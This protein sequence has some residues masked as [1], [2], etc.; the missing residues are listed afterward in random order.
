MQTWTYP[1]KSGGSPYT[2]TLADDGKMGCT[3]RGWL[4][5]KEGKP[6]RC[7]HIDQA[8]KSDAL[9]LEAR[10]DYMYAVAKGAVQSALPDPEPV[11]LPVADL[12]A[13]MLASK[14]PNPVKRND[15][16]S[17]ALFE[18]TYATGAFVLE[19]K[20]DGE[21]GFIVKSG[22]AVLAFSRPRAGETAKARE[23]SPAIAAA[24][25][26]VGDS[27]IDG[28]FVV[29]GG[30]SWDVKRIGA[31]VMFIAFDILYVNGESCMAKTYAERRLLLLTELAK[32]P[33]DQKVVSTVL[34]QPVAWATVEAIWA[35]GGEGAILK[36][37]SSTYR[38]TRS[39]DW[40]KVKEENSK[41]VTIIGF[42][43]AKS[44][45][46]SKVVVR[47]PNGKETSVKSLD[48]ATRR[49]M[50]ANP[51]KYLGARLVINYH[52]ETP[53]GKLRHPMYDHLA[54]EGE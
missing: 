10:G 30:K 39:A 2:L 32:L 28:E 36:R 22:G 25:A 6:R 47:L 9:T 24:M 43:A 50:A 41:V 27:L 48:N 14:M 5:K 8:A 29:P 16:V 18:K 34:S 1:S 12:P 44:G 11:V 3:C 35:K 54:G 33:V 37:V 19:E 23:L 17:I 7:T 46:H 40:V 21:R 20:L 52:I 51:A 53:D 42:E 38:E 26:H 4:I 45:P 13:P 15:P 49:D 31:Y